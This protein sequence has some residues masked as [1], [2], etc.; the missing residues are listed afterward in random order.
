MKRIS[1][2]LDTNIWF[3]YLISDILKEIDELVF[4]KSI[5]LIF[6]EELLEEFINVASRKK[7]EKYFSKEQIESLLRTFDE[8]GKI[9]N[10]STDLLLC[11]DIKDNF[12]L[13]LAVDSNADFLVTGDSD[14]L[15]LKNINQTSIVTINEFLIEIEHLL[16]S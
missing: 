1:V 7:F 12:L 14:L 2:I 3:S 5:L 15:V 16:N 6:S 4:N 9:I 13:N 8:Y 11:R 10:V